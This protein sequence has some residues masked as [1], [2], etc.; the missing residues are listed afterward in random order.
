V[1]SFISQ[2]PFLGEDSNANVQCVPT[3][4]DALMLEV[5]THTITHTHTLSLSLTHLSLSLTHTSLTRWYPWYAGTSPQ[6]LRTLRSCVLHV[7]HREP[8][9]ISRVLCVLHLSSVVWHTILSLCV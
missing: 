6:F 3:S 2:C 4:G 8:G 9:A 7:A 5:N 1:C